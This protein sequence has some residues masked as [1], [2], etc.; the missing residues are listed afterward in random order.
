MPALEESTHS[1]RFSHPTTRTRPTRSR[2]F[3]LSLFTELSGGAMF[4]KPGFQHTPFSEIGFWHWPFAETQS[5]EKAG[6][7]R[8]RPSRDAA[9]NLVGFMHCPGPY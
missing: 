9:L 2:P 3:L 4:G 5:I 1:P 6:V 8:P 7:I